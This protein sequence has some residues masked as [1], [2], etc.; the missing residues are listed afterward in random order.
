MYK[1]RSVA[2]HRK[3][4]KSK[5]SQRTKRNFAKRSTDHPEVKLS[6]NQP[7]RVPPR[8]SVPVLPT[9]CFT[10]QLNCT[11]SLHHFVLVFP[12]LLFFVFIKIHCII[13]ND[14]IALL[15]FIYSNLQNN[16]PLTFYQTYI[17][18]IPL[19]HTHKRLKSLQ[20]W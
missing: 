10:H 9:V 5:P 17:F 11:K 6:T 14:Y 7:Q 2:S 18:S 16:L 20:T 19:Q 1:S 8:P 13:E 12:P 15:C 3:S 4:N